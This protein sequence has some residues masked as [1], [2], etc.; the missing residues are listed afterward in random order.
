MKQTNLDELVQRIEAAFPMEPYTG[1]EPKIDPRD[2]ESLDYLEGFYKGPWYEQT[3]K[4]VFGMN[5]GAF[6]LTSETF[7]YFLPAYMRTW[8]RRS[9]A[10]EWVPNEILLAYFGFAQGDEPLRSPKNLTP[11]K[12]GVL[13][14][15]LD[16]YIRTVVSRDKPL[17]ASGLEQFRKMFAVE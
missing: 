9:Q 15:W 3:D 11:I 13:F 5:M 1:P 17:Y 14:D 7:D 4:E 12:R 2:T 6:F 16:W 8:I 10:G